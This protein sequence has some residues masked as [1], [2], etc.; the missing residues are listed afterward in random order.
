MKKRHLST[1][2]TAAIISMVICSILVV[3]FA[4][5]SSLNENLTHEFEDRVSAES[6]EIS[7]ILKSRLSMVENRLKELAADNTVR[8]TLMLGADQQLQ[9][10]LDKV[11]GSETAIHFFIA[12]EKPEKFFSVSNRDSSPEKIINL[13]NTATHPGEIWRDHDNGFSCT[14]SMPII[15]RKIRLGSAVCIYYFKKD[16]FLAQLINSKKINGLLFI[17]KKKIWNLFTGNPVHVSVASFGKFASESPGYLNIG[18]N[19]TLVI[20]NHGFPEIVYTASLKKLNQARKH[21][22]T[23]LA[24]MSAGIIFLVFLFSMFLGKKLTYPI[25]K[26]SQM[27]LEIAKGESDFSPASIKSNIVEVEDLKLSLNTML[28]NLQRAEELKRYQQLFEGVSDI[29]FIHDLSGNIIEANQEALDQLGYEKAEYLQM[30]LLDIISPKYHEQIEKT[31]HHLSHKTEPEVFEAEIYTKQ[32]KTIFTICHL[33]RIQYQGKEVLLIVIRDIT[34]RWMTEQAL[35]ES[36]ERYRTIVENSHDGIFIINDNYQFEYVNAQFAQICDRAKD[37]FIGED[38]RQFLTAKNKPFV[39]D[40]Y[41]RHCRGE[42]VS[43][44]CE[45]D[46]SRPDGEKRHVE[47]YATAINDSKGKIKIIG[48]IF[49]LTEKELAEQALRE[50]ELKYHTILDKS[51]IGYYE[52]D[53][54]GNFTFVSDVVCKFF[55]AKR[56]QL[57]GLSYKAYTD[58]ETA[59]KLYL[60][61]NNVFTSGESKKRFEYQI[62]LRDKEIRTVETAVSLMRDQ[63]GKPLGFRGLIKD[64]TDQKNLEIRLQMAHKMEAIGTLAGGIAH[65]FN[66]ILSAILGYAQLAQ[67]NSAENPKVQKYINRLYLASERAKKLVQQILVFSRQS[68]SEKRP[69]DISVVIKEALKLL[70]AS[71]PSTIEIHQNV[72]SNLGTV[73][74]DLTQIHQIVMNLCTNAFHAMEKDGGQLDVDLISVKISAEDSLLYEDIEPGYY[75]KLTVA[76][77]GHGISAEI[78]PRIFEPYFTTKELGKGTGMG[79]ATVHGIVKDHGGH[80]KIYSEPDVGT[81]FHILFPFIDKEAEP[82]PLKTSDLIPQGN[83]KILFVDDE[84]FLIDVGKELLENLGYCVETRISPNDALEAF[85]VQPDTYDLVITDMT[86]PKMNGVI[87]AEKIRKIRPDIPIILCSGYSNKIMSDDSRD[88]EFN[89]VLMKPVTLHE[90]ANMIRSVLNV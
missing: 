82:L 34:D 79:L 40:N 30:N 50:S 26:L 66:N 49:D 19:P 5:Y 11:Y 39:T 67:M 29:I 46:I 44:C 35:Y 3:S 72:K 2:I 76:D 53:I 38:F 13:L 25:D 90:L 51:E 27:A 8:V 7:Q 54:A 12:R 62:I 80:I 36:E 71:I 32:K 21:V 85:R 77:T 9:E 20:A 63:Y 75:L 17:G 73:E 58:E 18:G 70:R 68:K 60:I 45:L 65:D 56:K 14:Y 22:F 81:T 86:M 83:E 64:M 42:D 48:Q 33:R 69:A 41:V 84:K 6:G 74:A 55:K 15:R 89:G 4:L 47:L 57:E 16:R 78:L 59:N 31:F 1:Y 43:R 52:V 61:Y 87:L 88:T 37:E 23:L 28:A 10:Y 24:G